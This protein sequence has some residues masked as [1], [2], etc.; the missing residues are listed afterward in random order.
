MVEEHVENIWLF[1]VMG[2]AFLA[3]TGF[4]LLE[5]GIAR[6]QHGSVILV[7]NFL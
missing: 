7:K 3:L 4:A 2:F 5:A 1:M 6:K